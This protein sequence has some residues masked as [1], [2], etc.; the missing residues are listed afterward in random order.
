MLV[1]ARESDEEIPTLESVLA[2]PLPPCQR[3]KSKSHAFPH[4]VSSITI[5]IYRHATKEGFSFVQTLKLDPI[6]LSP[7]NFIFIALV[8]K[9][10]Q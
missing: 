4:A 9:E 1:Q 2:R 5:D 7:A 10:A 6:F 3:L 8:Y